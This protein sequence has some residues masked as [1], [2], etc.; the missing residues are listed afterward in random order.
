M[1]KHYNPLLTC[2]LL[3]SVSGCQIGLSKGQPGPLQPGATPTPTP[4]GFMTPQPPPRPEPTPFTPTG[5]P[6]PGSQPTPSA[7]PDALAL[8]GLTSYCHRIYCE[9]IADA[10]AASARRAFYDLAVTPEGSHIYLSQMRELNTPDMPQSHPEAVCF[11]WLPEQRL[12]RQIV[13]QLHTASGQ[14]SP[15]KI[16]QSYDYSCTVGSELEK[17]ASDHLLLTQT[18][19]DHQTPAPMPIKHYHLLQMQLPQHTATV[20]TDI[21][22]EM[23][24]PSPSG[25]PKGRALGQL[26]ASPGDPQAV[27]YSAIAPGHMAEKSTLQRQALQGTADVQLIGNGTGGPMPFALL[28]ASRL[29]YQG[30]IF[31]PP[32]PIE[33]ETLTQNQAPWQSVRTANQSNPE[34]LQ[35]LETLQIPSTAHQVF[36]RLAP[37]ADILYL[38]LGHLHQIWALELNTLQLRLLAGTGSPGHQD[39]SGPEARFE[40]PGAIDVDK[41]GYLY[42]LDQNNRAI[43]KISPAGEVST[44]YIQPEA[45]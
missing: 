5:T 21:P 24:D 17:D 10:L 44:L 33:T 34:A 25:W 9:S 12:T 29:F 11:P 20:I 41:A 18:V 38:S 23:P 2:L 28:P 30:A 36:Y 26:L 8:L 43:R 19:F 3:G 31:Q 6:D 22:W 40:K 27:Y 42:V 7:S 37:S 13:H 35:L 14:L 4:G 1:V 32:Y 39:S 15:L 45:P 16:N